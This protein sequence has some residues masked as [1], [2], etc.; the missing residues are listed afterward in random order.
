MIAN[1]FQP[2]NYWFDVMNSD[3][4]ISTAKPAR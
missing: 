4:W 1:S 2:Y 3:I